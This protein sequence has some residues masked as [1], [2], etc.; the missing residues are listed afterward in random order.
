MAKQKIIMSLQDEKGEMFQ[1]EKEIDIGAMPNI[2]VMEKQMNKI[3][4]QGSALLFDH[5]LKKNKQ[6]RWKG[7]YFRILALFGMGPLSY[8]SYVRHLSSCS[9]DRNSPPG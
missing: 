8:R 1:V 6:W 2:Q 3:I 5:G 7:F 9:K 4:A